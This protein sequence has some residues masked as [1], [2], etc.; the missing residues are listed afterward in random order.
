[1]KRLVFGFSVLSVIIGFTGCGSDIDTVK[2]GVLNFNKT[3]T[4][5]QAL[6]NNKNCESKEWSTFETD[7]GIKVVNFTCNVANVKEYIESIKDDLG[8]LEPKWKNID[9]I[10]HLKLKSRIKIYQF[11]INKDDTF[12]ANSVTEKY[13]WKDGTVYTRNLNINQA[14]ENAYK[15]NMTYKINNK[16][17]GQSA[18]IT[19]R[20]LSGLYILG[21]KQ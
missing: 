10:K 20:T 13:I 17:S 16:L 6:D 7:S 15:S 14:L 12:Q 8:T 9:N 18:Y 3:T 4:V 19:Q 1:M 5:G 2:D 11:T 21:K